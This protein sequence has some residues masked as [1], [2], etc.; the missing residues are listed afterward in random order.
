MS[1]YHCERCNFSTNNRTKFQRHLE[2]KKHKESPFSHHLVTKKPPFLDPKVTK[3]SPFSHQKTTIFDQKVDENRHP[4]KYCGKTFKFKQGM[5]RHVKYYCKKSE[6]E[7][8]KELV[9][10]MNEQM[11][12]KDRLLEEKEKKVEHYE[13]QQKKQLKLQERNNKMIKKLTNKLQITNYNHQQNVVV[14]NHIQLLNYQDTDLSHLTSMDYMG[15]INKVNYATFEI[16]KKI[17]FNPSKPENMNIYIPNIKDKYVVM[18]QENAWQIQARNK[19]VD[20][21]ME[22]KYMVLKEWYDENVRDEAG[23]DQLKRN[24][25]RFDANIE[26]DQVRD[27]I[28]DEIIMFLYNKRNMFVKGNEE[29]DASSI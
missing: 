17:H 20:N 15:A 24:F 14:N 12:E 9:R 10:L 22:D 2:T 6:D 11:K 18:F 21:L 1:K 13:S 5:Y 7:D 26:N 29:L 25:E 19:E 27:R 3:K 28:R 16:I 4:C 23:Y 8:V